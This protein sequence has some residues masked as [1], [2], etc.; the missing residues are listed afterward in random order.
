MKKTSLF[1]LLAVIAGF[2][3]LQS[4]KSFQTV[5]T[6][7]DFYSAEA[8]SIID[9]KCYGCHS[10]KGRSQDARDALM[11]D[12]LPGLPKAK[13]VASI[14]DIIKAV[15]EDKMPPETM[16]ARMPEMKMQPE[17]KTALLQWSEKKAESLLK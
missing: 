11:W 16:V 7:G 2:F 14:N 9:K 15:K 8:K 1:A 6:G 10:I 12:S 13:I 17:E 4:N 3:L 5:Q